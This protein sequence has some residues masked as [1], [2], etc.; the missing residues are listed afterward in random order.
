M[1]FEIS[2]RTPEVDIEWSTP[3]AFSET[4][5]TD[6]ILPV[7]D[8]ASYK[9]QKNYP[10][11]FWM[12]NLDELVMYESKLEMAVLLQLDFNQTVN[13]VVPQ[14]FLMRYIHGSKTYRHTP[15]FLVR[16]NNGAAEV[17]NVKPKKWVD[18]EKNQRAF[19]A[20]RAA[21]NQMGFGYTTRSEPDSV[22]IANLR[23]LGGY[24]RRPP[25]T[26]L[27]LDTLLNCAMQSMTIGDAIK[28]TEAPALL[29]PVLF[30]LLWKGVLH[31][32]PHELMGLSTKISLRGAK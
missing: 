3:V 14:P 1:S 21:S 10:G 19:A 15:D 7:R 20:C 30:Y 32:N 6:Q 13:A 23:W 2:Y 17:I 26:D 25:T 28:T 4:A 9:G 16:Y 24:R 18:T 12:S 31:F 27:F 11:Y 5:L 8:A 29:R 22:L